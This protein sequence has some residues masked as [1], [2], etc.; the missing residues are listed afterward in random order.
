MAN[1]RERIGAAI[2]G[3]DFAGEITAQQDAIMRMWEAYIDGPYHLPPE[4]LLRQLGEYAPAVDELYG[5]DVLSGYSADTTDTRGRAILE[6]R[7]LWQQNPLAIWIVNTWTSY[8]LGEG[9]K[10][11]AE[12]EGANKVWQAAYTADR[13][14]NVFAEDRIHEVSNWTVIDG[15]VFIAAY[16]ST[17]DGETTFTVMST[18]EITEI[19][20]DPDDKTTPLYYKREWSSDGEQRTLYYPDWVAIQETDNGEVNWI[21]E[22]K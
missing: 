15:N 7:R 18:D 17:L 12:D 20:A 9:I 2:S 3:R 10:I 14:A 1:I 6:S 13:N 11:N 21:I 5:W 22:T 19:I 8:G 16:A 4:E